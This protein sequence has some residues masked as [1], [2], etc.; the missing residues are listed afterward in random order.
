MSL[1][2]YY[3]V[4]GR[5]PDGDNEA[6]FYG[7]YTYTDDPMADYIT[8]KVLKQFADDIYGGDMEAQREAAARHGDDVVYIDALL[9]SDS[10]INPCDL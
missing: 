2:A 6:R 8:S 3:A 7:P 4:V 10:P 1:Q 9:F 5:I